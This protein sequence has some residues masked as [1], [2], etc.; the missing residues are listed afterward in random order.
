MIKPHFD[1]RHREDK[2]CGRVVCEHP[3]TAHITYMHACTDIDILFLSLSRFLYFSSHHSFV[4]TFL[5]FFKFFLLKSSISQKQ[6]FIYF[7]RIS[8]QYLNATTEFEATFYIL[9]LAN[10]DLWLIVAPTIDHRSTNKNSR[11]CK[12]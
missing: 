6:H 8:L 3:I 1:V 11:Y 12:I 9:S 4:H 7:Y 10:D 5:K 2:K